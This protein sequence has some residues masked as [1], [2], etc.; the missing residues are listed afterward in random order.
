MDSQRGGCHK[1]CVLTN[2][3]SSLINGYV[4][5]TRYQSVGRATG[6]CS[7]KQLITTIEDVTSSGL[8]A[9][10]SIDSD[11]MNRVFGKRSMVTNP[12]QINRNR[13]FNL[14]RI[15]KIN[16]YRITDDRGRNVTT[17]RVPG[18]NGF[19]GTG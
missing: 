13:P 10:A 18:R 4:G 19:I 3:R 1:T 16:Q 2:Q 5:F 11:R 15:K 6:Q 7:C 9:P 12:L 14:T 8:P 17:G